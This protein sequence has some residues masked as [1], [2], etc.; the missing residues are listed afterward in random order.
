ME[1][2]AEEAEISASGRRVVRKES[3]L[4]L[5]RV[6]CLDGRNSNEGAEL[7]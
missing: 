3:R 2:E 6:S 4:G 1:L 5:G 7:V